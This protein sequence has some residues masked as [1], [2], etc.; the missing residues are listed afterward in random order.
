MTLPAL[1]AGEPAKLTLELSASVQQGATG[2]IGTVQAVVT[3]AWG[4]ATLPVKDFEVTLKPAALAADESCRSAKVSA[5]GS[6]RCKTRQGVAA[7]H[8]V[9]LKADADG[10]FTLTA[11]CKSRAVVCT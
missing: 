7:F 3:D 11:Y 4:N 6:N 5:R 9:S 1:H 2:N 10:D 8:E